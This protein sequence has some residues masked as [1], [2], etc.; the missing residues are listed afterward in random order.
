MLNASELNVIIYVNTKFKID[1]S[2]WKLK[3]I[4]KE[5]ASLIKAK[6]HIIQNGLDL[7]YGNICHSVTHFLVI[8]VVVCHLVLC[9]MMYFICVE[10]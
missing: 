6:I 7:R 5:T 4:Q 1:S 9:F 2:L 3:S 10:L 8:P